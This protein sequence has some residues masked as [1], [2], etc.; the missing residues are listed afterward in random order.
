MFSMIIKGL[1]S[2]PKPQKNIQRHPA[3]EVRNV[4]YNLFVEDVFEG[5]VLQKKLPDSVLLPF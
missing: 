3:T 5:K 2:L 1:L 4:R